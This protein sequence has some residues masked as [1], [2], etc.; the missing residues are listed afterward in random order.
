MYILLIIN[1]LRVKLIL[2]GFFFILHTVTIL[3]FVIINFVN[4]KR[5]KYD[6]MLE[7]HLSISI[8]YLWIYTMQN[9]CK[10][11][12]NYKV[13]ICYATICNL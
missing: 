5:K 4:I 6:H 8:R 12:F 9:H 1:M 7:S 13:L 3:D 11:R 2:V 10:I